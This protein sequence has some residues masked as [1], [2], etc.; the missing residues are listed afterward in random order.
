MES[1]GHD[2]NASEAIMTHAPAWHGIQPELGC[3][4]PTDNKQTCDG[5]AAVTGG[6][7]VVTYSCE[8]RLETNN[9]LTL[10]D[11]LVDTLAR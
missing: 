11:G 3:Q 5:P 7:D 6:H 4:Q 10:S 8:R 1:Q 2:A 9:S